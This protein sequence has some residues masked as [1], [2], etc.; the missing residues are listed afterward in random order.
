[1]SRQCFRSAAVP[2][3]TRCFAWLKD[4]DANLCFLASRASTDDRYQS[5]AKEQQ[6]KIEVETKKKDLLQFK[7]DRLRSLKDDLDRDAWMFEKC[8]D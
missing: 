8:G 2:T 7:L 3:A 4:T 6:H 5:I 1:M